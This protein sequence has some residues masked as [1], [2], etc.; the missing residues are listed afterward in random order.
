[1]PKMPVPLDIVLAIYKAFGRSHKRC[2]RTAAGDSLLAAHRKDTEDL[3]VKIIAK[4][5][6]LG[7]FLAIRGPGMDHYAIYRLPN[8]YEVRKWAVRDGVPVPDEEVKQASTLEEARK[9][10][11]EGLTRTPP[12]EGDH[13]VVEEVWI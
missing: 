12:M 13:H 1:M 4:Q 11:P 7:K 3:L 8:R 5:V 9:F 2:K 10:V 6:Q